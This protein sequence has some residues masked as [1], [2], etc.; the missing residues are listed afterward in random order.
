MRAGMWLMTAAFAAWSA[1]VVL[2][3]AR[4]IVLERERDL[5]WVRELRDLRDLRA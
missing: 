2:H 4:S 5:P 3:R 1:A